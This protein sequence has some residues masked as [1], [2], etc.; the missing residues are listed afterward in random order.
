[1]KTLDVV[2]LVR[3][4]PEEGLRRGQVG[5]IVDTPSPGVFL[6]EFADVQ[7]EAYAF[8]AAREADLLVL[9]HRPVLKVA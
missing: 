9:H 6:V 1:M 7:G 4:C 5:T 8:L 2:A 3:D